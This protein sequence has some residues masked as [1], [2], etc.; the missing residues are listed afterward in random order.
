MYLAMQESLDRQVAIKVFDA[1]LI[2]DAFI[3]S[4][5]EQESKL[6]ASLNHPNIVQVIDQGISDQ[7]R[8]YFCNAL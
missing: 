5:F 8:P 3:K 6:I 7:G 2:D 1:S 4:Q